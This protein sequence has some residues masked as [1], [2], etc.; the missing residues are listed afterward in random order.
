MLLTLN[1][2][3]ATS[4]YSYQKVEAYFLHVCSFIRMHLMVPVYC[5]YF[6]LRCIRL[7]IVCQKE[8]LQVGFFALLKQYLIKKKVLNIIF[9]KTFK[10]SFYTFYFTLWSYLLIKG[11]KILFSMGAIC[12]INLRT[13]QMSLD[14]WAV[15]ALGSS[16]DSPDIRIFKIEQYQSMGSTHL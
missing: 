16:K 7:I 1:C 9:S 11:T 5:G 10:L 12:R 8:P 4:K 14:K 2:M 15:V 3:P 6:S 13:W